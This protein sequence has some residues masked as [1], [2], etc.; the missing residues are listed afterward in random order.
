[1]CY[2]S[3]RGRRSI[4]SLTSILAMQVL[5]YLGLAMLQGMQRLDKKSGSSTLMQRKSPGSAS[6]FVAAN[7]GSVS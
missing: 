6:G 4:C 5:R 2:K 7:S 3:G 1:M